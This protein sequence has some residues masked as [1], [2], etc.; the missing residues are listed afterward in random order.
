MCFRPRFKVAWVT[1]AVA[2]AVVV[3]LPRFLVAPLD[4][5]FTEV[6]VLIEIRVDCM[7]YVT[8]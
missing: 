3:D 4:G 7:A 2:A 5:V 8:P 6:T 1:A